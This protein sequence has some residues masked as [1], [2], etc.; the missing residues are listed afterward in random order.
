MSALEHARGGITSSS[1]S[2]REDVGINA[3]EASVNKLQ[4][5]IGD[6]VDDC[7]SSVEAIRHEMGELSAKLN[8][9]I[10][11]VGNQPTL[12]LGGIELP[13][14][15]VSEPRH[16]GGARNV[17]KVENFLFDMEQYFRAVRADSEDLKV[18]MAT[19]YLS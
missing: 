12:A 16:Y 5:T 15:K 14:A 1:S 2:P 19:M 3:L 10:R 8:F 9:T 4:G 7:R 17:K 6:V 13:R 18:S 11:A